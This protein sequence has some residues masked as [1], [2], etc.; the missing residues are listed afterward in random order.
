M[1]NELQADLDR[2][3]KSEAN[4]NT[5]PSLI[6]KTFVEAARKYANPLDVTKALALAD[7]IGIRHNGH[8]LNAPELRLLVDAALG[9]TE[10]E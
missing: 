7:S 6:P 9:V 1:D 3:D 4:P 8:N 2:Y 5:L 10:D